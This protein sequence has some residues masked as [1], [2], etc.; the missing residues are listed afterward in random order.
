MENRFPIGKGLEAYELSGDWYVADED[1]D[2]LYQITREQVDCV[3]RF[4]EKHPDRQDDIYRLFAT[5]HDPA[6][7]QEEER[8]QKEIFGRVLG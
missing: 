1:F 8:L 3:A 7:V 5:D 4:L 6:P 2:V